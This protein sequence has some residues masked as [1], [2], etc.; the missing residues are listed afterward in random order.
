MISDIITGMDG[1]RS[2]PDWAEA[3]EDW[4]VAK[5]VGRRSGDPGHADRA[6]RND[7]RRWA[8]AINT[9][10]GREFV[11]PPVSLEGWRFVR[12]E[13]GDSDTLVRALD[14]LGAELSTATRQRMLSTLRGFC[15]YAVRRGLLDVDPSVAEELTVR[16]VTNDDIKAFTDDEVN[17]LMDVAAQPAS[18]RLRAA[19]PVRD[20]AIIA[21]L[22]F[23]GLRVSELCAL[24]DDAVDRHGDRPLLRLVDGTKGGRHRVVPIPSPTLVA[25]EEYLDQRGDSAGAMF[26]R[27]NGVDMSQQTIDN[28]LRQ[29]AQVADVSPPPGAMAHALR[30]AYGM[31]LALRGVHLTVI[32]QLMGH[33]DPRTTSAYT[34]AHATGLGDALDEA[35]LL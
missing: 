10:S 23:C 11:E 26:V 27:R 4:L 9:V 7:L 20:V 34:R 3:A 17:R 29:L 18:T 21:I 24:R 35:G 5:R 8:E 12:T 13:L 15:S 22:A 1:V 32:Q 30:H 31:R 28:R 2:T 14:L 33:T 16:R 25:I 6:R 19:W